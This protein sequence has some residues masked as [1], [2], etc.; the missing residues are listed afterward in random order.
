MSKSDSALE[1]VHTLYVMQ[2]ELIDLL[3]RS[4]L[5]DPDAR[6]QARKQMKEFQELLDRAD[7]RYMG[8]EDVWDSL[9]RLPQEIAKKI[10]VSSAATL[11]LRK[12]TR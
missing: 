5:Q 1:T 6:R 8:G 3:E 11:R 9:V 2:T 12:K 10:R 4:D 7:R